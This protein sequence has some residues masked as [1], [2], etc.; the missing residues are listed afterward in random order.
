[1]T[2]QLVRREAVNNRVVAPTSAIAT[3]EQANKA[4]KNHLSSPFIVRAGATC[5]MP[6]AAS[7]SL[8][9][10][11]L[12]TYLILVVQYASKSLA[13]PSLHR[14]SKSL[15]LRQSTTLTLPLEYIYNFVRLMAL[16]SQ[17]GGIAQQLLPLVSSSVTSPRSSSGIMWPSVGPSPSINQQLV[18]TGLHPLC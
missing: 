11:G 18:I 4:N 10:S 2:S 3:F 15:A 6:I 7:C 17:R 8:N 9:F 5:S 16:T 1:M 12:D 14:A 13:L